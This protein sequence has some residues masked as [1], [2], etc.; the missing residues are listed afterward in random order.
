[1]ISNSDYKKVDLIGAMMSSKI[2]C[3]SCVKRLTLL[4]SKILCSSCVKRLT[5]L[6]QQCDC[7]SGFCL[8]LDTSLLARIDEKVDLVQRKL[9]LACQMIYL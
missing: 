5:L 9:E 3:S 8:A 4:S 2:L 7:E 6:I 1:M